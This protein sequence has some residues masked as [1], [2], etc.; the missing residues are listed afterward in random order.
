MEILK[1]KIDNTVNINMNIK[2]LNIKQTMNSETKT[3][4][5]KKIIGEENNNNNE[6]ETKLII[7][8]KDK[9]GNIIYKM[10]R[11]IVTYCEDE[12]S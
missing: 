9:K 11:F 10:G 6:T 7:L 12:T 2:N 3:D 8:G 4:T 5:H 1:L